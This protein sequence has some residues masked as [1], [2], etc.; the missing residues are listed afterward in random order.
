MEAKDS[1]TSQI[2]TDS[3]ESWILN[4]WIGILNTSNFSTKEPDRVLLTPKDLFH[5]EEEEK[6][7]ILE[8]FRKR[9]EYAKYSQQNT[10][11]TSVIGIPNFLPSSFLSRANQIG[12]SVCRIVRNFPHEDFIKIVEY[13]LSLNSNNFDSQDKIKEIFSIP[14]SLAEEIFS[15]SNLRPL[16][17]LKNITVGQLAK[18]NPLPIGTGFLVGGTH[19]MTNCHVISSLEVACQCIAQFNYIDEPSDISQSIIEYELA[20]QELFVYNNDPRMDYVI[21]QLKRYSSGK[22]TGYQFGWITLNE[23]NDNIT[24]ALD[25][26]GVK[27]LL[28]K[29][30]FNEQDLTS[31]GWTSENPNIPGEPVIIIQHPKGRRKQII[32][33]NNQV[34]GLK[35]YFL[36]Y[37]ADSDYGSSGSPVLNTK[38]ELVALNH[39]AI[40]NHLNQEKIITSHT[41]QKT[42]IIAEQGI[43][44]CRIVEDLK[45]KSLSNPKLRSFIQDFVITS[46][47]LNYP[48]LPSALELDGL[49]DYILLRDWQQKKPIDEFSIEAL[50]CP[51][52]N[53]VESTIFSKFFQSSSADGIATL[54]YDSI[55]IYLTTKGKIVFSRKMY[56]LPTLPL[57]IPEEENKQKE[58]ICNLQSILKSL[59]SSKNPTHAYYSYEPS[60]KYDDATKQALKKFVSDFNENKDQEKQ[61]DSLEESGDIH[62]IHPR[63]LDA[64]NS[65]ITFLGLYELDYEKLNDDNGFKIPALENPSRG[66]IVKAI[67]N[68]LKSLDYYKAESNGCFDKTTADAVKHFQKDYG[69]KSDGV[70]GP[71]T[72]KMIALIQSYEYMTD[73]GVQFGQFNHI[74]ITCNI[75]K[76]L[77]IYINGKRCETTLS[78]ALPKDKLLKI[79]KSISAQKNVDLTQGSPLFIGAYSNKNFVIPSFPPEGNLWSFFKG[80]I[81]E[82]RLWNMVRKEKNINQDKSRRLSSQQEEGLIGYWRFEEGEGNEICNLISKKDKSEVKGATWLRQS[83]FPTPP[84]PSALNFNC[85]DHRVDCGNNSGLDI[86][87]GITVEAW[88]KHV[89]GNALIVSRGC[90]K[91]DDKRHE[92]GYSLSWLSGRIRVELGN[93]NNKS[94]SCVETQELAPNDKSW[95]HIAFT[96]GKLGEDDNSHEGQEIEIYIDGKRQNCVVIAGDYKSMLAGGQHKTWGIFTAPIGKPDE[97]LHIGS[98]KTSS[99]KD[100]SNFFNISITDVR[101]WKL[102]RTQD[103]IKTNLFRRV[104]VDEEIKNGLIGYWRLDEGDMKSVRNLVTTN[105]N[106]SDKECI[107]CA[108]DATWVPQLD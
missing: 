105:R 24:P 27:N 92:N 87:D 12:L 73:K 1:H 62:T 42:Q 93:N 21:I 47:Q 58:V 91:I 78:S 96:W 30:G 38:L 99:I 104:K 82:V 7:K 106:G 50:I 22:Q 85:E 102:A 16:E 100:N 25:R 46:E 83:N 69:L 11:V 79:Q 70:A 56:T 49:N 88:I 6:D 39:A 20:P 31:L 37:E 29:N 5:P 14:Q 80:A 77:T 61:I 8:T 52:S 43:R 60:G 63:I 19:L 35:K 57:E 55:R 48:P 95:H 44:I 68:I 89:Y 81:A 54:G 26:D 45:K 75:G 59:Y 107:S 65:E 101:L 94:Y 103:Q 33:Y 17:A 76:K 67:Q 15:N 51:Y 90:R 41:P 86:T 98:G 71:L 72:Q 4:D 32:L 108:V 18:L 34:N 84:L 28:I 53:E 3:L 2:A 66:E 13:A 23:D 9:V 40:P 10:L 64:L 74:A 36:R 97:T